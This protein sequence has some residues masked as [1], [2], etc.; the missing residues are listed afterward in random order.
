KPS[1]KAVAKMLAFL[2][3]HWGV[4]SAPHKKGQELFPA[5]EAAYKK[6]YTLFGMK[7]EH[8]FVFT[9]SA[10]EAI[11]HVFAST[12]HS[13]TD[14]TG[15]NQYIISA[16]EEAASLMA[17]SRLEAM[18]CVIKTVKPNSVGEV[19]I[20]QI[21]DAITPRTALVSLSFANGLTGV[22]FPLHEI[23]ELCAKRGIL[24]HVNMTHAIG[25]VFFDSEEIRP[26]FIT[27]NGDHLHAPK[28]TGGLF[29]KE[30]VKCAPFILGGQEQAG[31]RA[32]NLS[33]ALLA[34]LGEA[35]EETKD[36]A[37][38]MCTEIAR[39]RN[40]LED[41]IVKAVPDATVFFQNEMR[42][43]HISLIGFPGISNE[44]MLYHLNKK[45]VFASIGGGSFQKINLLLEASLI[46]KK[47]AQEAI[48]FTLSRYTTE[49]EIERAAHIIAECVSDLK[50]LSLHMD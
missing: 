2:T 4:P 46:D 30:G 7:E 5:M 43:P 25:K 14:P 36:A 42:L 21:A 12:Y 47:R 40:K 3:D 17:A 35:A 6:I 26:A 29:I 19:Q 31:L 11:N 20:E 38:F 41:K 28:G 8:Q 22:I 27:F 39:L 33:V 32:G 1:D 49:D 10:E 23:A 45:G 16:I 24:L 13:V 9:S 18:G 15:K 48:N 44:L 37:D 50:K 34:A